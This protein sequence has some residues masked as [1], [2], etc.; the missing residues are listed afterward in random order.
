MHTSVLSFR[1]LATPVLVVSV[2]AALAALWPAHAGQPAADRH[3]ALVVIV[4]VDQMRAEFLTRYARHWSSGFKRLLE[5]GAIFD[6]AYYPYLNTVTCAGHATIGTGAWPKTHGIILNQW[7]RREL[8]AVRPC[9]ADPSATTFTYGGTPGGDGHSA[10]ALAVPTLAERMRLRW[11]TSRAVT[12]SL[13]ARSA[14]MMAG[15]NATAVTWL[16]ASGWQ[17][18]SAYGRLR[19]EL[20]RFFEAQPFT[21]DGGRV[22]E[23]LHPADAYSGADDG[24]GERP[25]TGWT[26]VFPH[27]L[28]ESTAH[29]YRELWEESPYS[30]AYLGQLA[31][32]AVRDFAL[33]Q[34]GVTDFLGVSF[35]ATDLVGHSFGP[36]SHEVQDVLTRLDR[37]LGALLDTLDAAVGRE[38]YVLALSS[39]H[40][41]AAVPEAARAAGQPAGRV[42]LGLVRGTVDKA[43][44][45]LG[46]GP[47]VARAE[48]TQVYLT[49]EA[50]ARATSAAVAPAVEALR[51]LPG[52]LT[53]IWNGDLD[54]PNPDVMPENPRGDPGRLRARPERRH[55]RRARARLDSRAR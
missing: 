54:G 38:G 45:A 33:G 13:K 51:R 11:R 44:S 55:H 43:L 3:P 5:Q 31:A 28:P 29:T 47:H 34:R 39:D 9:T 6:Q 18:S 12:M 36:D 25:A 17:T 1:R 8:G 50:R 42:P 22:W 46:A 16:G 15:R 32:A 41:V 23:R 20:M 37:T 30:D 21:A 19:P 52:I 4:V 40:G 53:A 35:S 10:H 26:A 24:V 49:R 2:M 7:Y 48:Y 14:I 27:Q